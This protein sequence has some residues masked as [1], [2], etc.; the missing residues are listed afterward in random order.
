MQ[1]CLGTDDEPVKGLWVN[2]SEQINAVVV[3]YRLHDEGE[4]ATEKSL[5][6]AS[7]NLQGILQPLQYLLE[8]QHN[9]AWA[10]KKFLQNF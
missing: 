10:I 8:R 6:F 1:Q 3:C 2:I 5:I 4:T 7:L 9:R